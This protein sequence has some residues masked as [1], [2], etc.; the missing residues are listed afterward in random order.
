MLFLLEYFFFKLLFVYNV[1]VMYVFLVLY[2]RGFK[3]LGNFYIFLII[4]K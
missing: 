3:N 4:G 1:K 2:R